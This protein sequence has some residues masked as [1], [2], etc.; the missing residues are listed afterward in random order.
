MH[1]KLMKPKTSLLLAAAGTQL[2]A[3]TALFAQTSWNVDAGG[4]WS[5]ATNWTGGVP[6]AVGAT[7]NFNNDISGN[8]D[9]TLGTISR[10]VGI[11]NIGDSNNTHRFTITRTSPATLT[12]NNGVSDAQINEVGAISLSAFDTI[13]VPVILASNLAVNAAGELSLNGVVS[14]SGGAKTITKSGAGILRLTQANT[15]T[16]VTNVNAGTIYISNNESLGKTDGNTVVASGA[17]VY[18]VAPLSALAEA[19]TIS[20][21]GVGGNG[22]LRIGGGGTTNLSGAVTLG[23]DARI[24]TDGSVTLTFTGGIDTAGK[25]L[26]LAPNGTAFN[27]N[28]VGISGTGG[29]VNK[30]F[31][32]AA[33]F[34]AVNSH[35]G[36]TNLNQGSITV[37]ASG[38]LS[39]TTATLSVNNTNSAAA[40]TN[41]VL[42]LT[43]G[44]DTTV[45]SLKGTIATPTSGTNTAT[46][47]TQTGRTFTVNQTTSES[48]EG[49]IAGA[50]GFTLGSLSTAS[51]TLSGTSTY[52]GAT[53]VN[54]GTLVVN[55][56]IS[57]SSLTTVAS[58]ATLGGIG[59]VGALSV[60]D[61]GTLAPGNS[62]GTLNT[63]TLSLANLSNLGFEL[64]PANT[65][66]GGGVND[67]VSVTGNL[68][69]DGILNLT[70]TS[71]NFLS[72]TTGTAWRLFNYTGSLT[73]NTLGFGS[74][75]S[76]GSG[77]SW[78][79]NT[80]TSGQVNLVVVPEPRAALLG[81]LGLL[82]LLRRRR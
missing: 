50:G 63:G 44:A 9:I 52:T 59:T 41:V 54:K 39:A 4:S 22:A 2:L 75:P 1:K 77:L 8:R 53:N 73:N 6:D 80:A 37:G 11:L 31:V 79:I 61:G 3:S 46:I 32:G 51:L 56:N 20:G 67:L 65:A 18:G 7:A 62:P 71:G 48:Y 16:G 35:T 42:N 58:T 60:L 74:M 29:V 5:T 27:V 12:L 25:I 81:G 82:M 13:S 40:G 34:N 21:T 55:G 33:T 78:Q 45:G 64:N 49:V 14:E 43:T 66:V 23:A 76:L 24:Q 17:T 47:N 72:V 70:P 28:T 69:L 68:T 36:A 10:T 26:T 30:N 19:F 57:T 15:Y 38:V